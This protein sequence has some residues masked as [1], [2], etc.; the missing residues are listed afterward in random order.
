MVTDLIETEEERLAEEIVVVTE[1]LRDLKAEMVSFQ[2][3]AREG[4][5]ASAKQSL[6]TL[7]AVREFLASAERTEA[8][9]ADYKRR[10]NGGAGQYAL[11]LDGARA[12]I[13]C[14]LDR[15]RRCHCA[16]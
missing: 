15:L 6:E 1:Q 7:K 4:D 5:I 10:E 9:L 2:R 8:R 14:R 3:R 13:R 11:D 16:G 12:S